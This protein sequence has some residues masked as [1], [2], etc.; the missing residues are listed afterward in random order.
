MFNRILVPT[1]FST[2]SQAA[3]DLARE[4]FPEAEMVLLHVIEPKRLASDSADQ[5]VSPI[6]MGEIRQGA[7]DAAKER[8]AGLAGPNDEVSVVVGDPAEQILKAVDELKP[9][10]VVMGTHGRRGLAHLFVGSVAEEV[11]RLAPVPV[12]VAKAR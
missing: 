11:V 4:H 9:E 10:V 5:M 3:L 6:N 8:L 2:C 7:Q 1:D 12:L